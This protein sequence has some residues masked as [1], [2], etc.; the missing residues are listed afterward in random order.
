MSESLKA[1]LLAT[2]TVVDSQHACFLHICANLPTLNTCS[3]EG[4]KRTYL[5]VIP[6]VSNGAVLQRPSVFYHHRQWLNSTVQFQS[7]SSCANIK[8]Y[9]L[10]NA[11]YKGTQ[12]IVT[13]RP[14]SEMVSS[15]RE[16]DYLY[17]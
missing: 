13:Y 3:N 12:V 15:V 1:D 7:N 16:Y 6:D 5:I 2:S 4:G 10:N 17:T 8:F 11:D 14:S 9:Q